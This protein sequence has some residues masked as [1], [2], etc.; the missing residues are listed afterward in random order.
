MFAKREEAPIHLDFNNRP[1]VAVCKCGKLLRG[2]TETLPAD[3][4]YIINRE[5]TCRDCALTWF[6]R[7]YEM[8]DVL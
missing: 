1:V 3:R 2:R 5:L 4:I 7:R 6:D 8:T